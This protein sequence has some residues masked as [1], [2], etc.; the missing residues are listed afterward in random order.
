MELLG[1]VLAVLGIGLA[2]I[3]SGVGSA[4]GVGRAGQAAAGVTAEDPDKFMK[5]LLLQLLPA[6][7]G[8]YG[9][10]VGFL[11]LI[12]INALSNPAFVVASTGTFLSVGGG[13]GMLMACLP[14][15]VGGLASAIY[16]GNVAVSSIG[17]VAKR[18]E[19][20]GKGMLLTV[21]VETYALLAFLVSFLAVF[22]PSWT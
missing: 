15:A 20:S 1:T 11:G 16:Q 9:F 13:L 22:I 4:I 10:I 6:T 2:V 8:L 21:M 12:K 18:P 3:L 5:C 19:E 14:I 17:L 7:Q